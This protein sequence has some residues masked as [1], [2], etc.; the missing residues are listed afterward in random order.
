MNI[1]QAV[2]SIWKEIVNSDQMSSFDFAF[3]SDKVSLSITYI[4]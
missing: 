2:P 4:I 3:E 1:C